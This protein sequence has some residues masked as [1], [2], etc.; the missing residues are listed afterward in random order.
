M[1]LV[2]GAAIGG[3]MADSLDF[4]ALLAPRC[5]R[6]ASQQIPVHAV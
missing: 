2:A 6:V 3:K 1:R 5:R 4:D